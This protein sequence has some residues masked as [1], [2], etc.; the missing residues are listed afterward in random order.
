MLKCFKQ[1]HKIGVFFLFLEM[2]ALLDSLKRAILDHLLSVDARVKD[3]RLNELDGGDIEGRVVTIGASRSPDGTESTKDLVDLALLNGDIVTVVALEI[4]SRDGGDGVEGDAVV[5][6]DNSEGVGTDLVGEV[7]IGG[8]TISAD[9]D[10]LDL[11]LLHQVSSHVIANDSVRDALLLKFEGRKASSLKQRTSLINV[12]VNLLSLAMSRTNDSQSSTNSNGGERTSVAVRQDVI[13]I[14]NERSSIFGHAVA[15]LLLMLH[16][17]DSQTRNVRGGVVLL[18]LGELSQSIAAVH[19]IHRGGTSS[20]QMRTSG[21]KITFRVLET[22]PSQRQ[23]RSTS[24]H[25]GSTNRQH[26]NVLIN[27]FQ[28]IHGQP[29]L[30]LGKKALIQ[31]LSK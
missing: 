30:L 1:I 8:N 10:A 6:G 9:E 31:D 4:D 16:K 13:T 14:L 20:L 11:S 2:V 19:Q 21:R 18:S 28:R 3:D 22:P 27:V 7:S 24:N 12:D 15:H 25:G 29:L 23:S 17:L 26:Q 5:L